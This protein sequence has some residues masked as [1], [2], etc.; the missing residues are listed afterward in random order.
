[1]KCHRWLTLKHLKTIPTSNKVGDMYRFER[2]TFKIKSFDDDFVQHQGDDQELL[3][4]FDSAVA[5]E[6]YVNFP[7]YMN[8]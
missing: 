4:G 2:C 6:W 3:T 5:S 8:S 7:G 1:M